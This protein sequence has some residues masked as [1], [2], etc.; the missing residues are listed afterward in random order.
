MMS[1]SSASWLAGSGRSKAMHEENGFVRFVSKP[2]ASGAA[3]EAVITQ[4]SGVQEVLAGEWKVADGATGGFTLS[5]RSTSLT[6]TPSARPPFVTQVVRTYT[7]DGSTGQLSY[8]IDMATTKTPQC[9]NHLSGEL[10]K[11]QTASKL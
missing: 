1:V 3:V 10:S 5:L 7:L 2:A 6:R 8:S 4:C 9:Q 11:Q